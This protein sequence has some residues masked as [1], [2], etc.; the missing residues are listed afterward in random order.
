MQG[1]V[2]TTAT[3][4][5]EPTVKRPRDPR[6]QDAL[7]AV[8]RQR[9]LSKEQFAHEL[10][11]DALSRFVEEL[12]L[13]QASRLLVIGASSG[14][15]PSVLG[16]LVGRVWVLEPDRARVASLE[17]QI[18]AGSTECPNLAVVHGS[19]GSGVPGVGQVDAILQLAPPAHELA[20]TLLAHLAP[21]GRALVCADD[22]MPPRRAVRVAS[23]S[24][25][26]VTTEALEFPRFLLPLGDLLVAAGVV[27]YEQIDEAARV[28]RQN[29]RN[30]GAELLATGAIREEDLYRALAEQRGMDFAETRDVLASLDPE[31]VQQLPR[32]YLDHYRFIPVRRDKTRVYVVT[33]N[34]ELPLWELQGAFE[35]AEVVVQLTTPTDLQRMRT[36]IELGLVAPA[37]KVEEPPRAEAP[38]PALQ[39]EESSRATN[40]LDALLQDSAAERASDVHL[41][42]YE[43]GARVRFRI[44]GSLR[45][46]DRYHLSAAEFVALVN[47]LKIASG[48]DIAERRAPQSGRFHRRAGG[49][50]FDLRA[51]TQPALHGEHVILRM[52]PQNHKPPSIEG[53]GFPQAVAE[54]YRRLLQNPHG[55]VLVV[56]PTGSGKSTTLYAGLQTLATDPTRKVITVEDP[57]EYEIPRVQQTMINPAVGFHFADAV[58]AFVREDPDVILVGEIRDAE[59][60]L[61]AIRASQTGHLVLSTLHCN[62]TVDA[63]Q[64]LSDLGMHP[65]SIAS[66]LTAV[67]SQRLAR[68]ICATC[69]A[70]AK[71]DPALLAELFPHG[72]PADFACFAGRGCARCSGSGT[73]G[74]IAVVE[75]L[76]VGP[77]IRKA[78]S[79]RAVLDEVREIAGC[80]GLSSL[81]ESALQLVGQGLIPLAE[82]YDVLSAEQMAPAESRG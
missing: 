70:P 24:E 3:K 21:G 61:E 33:P 59:T 7:A 38:G 49:R 60:A 22:A 20:P 1:S 76:Q 58:R 67:M 77:T 47:V 65:N 51:Q 37:P 71:P 42:F 23:S 31:V 54:R 2:S 52:L 68:R 56:G 48:M 73:R 46:I 66:E 11:P 81:R 5:P 80:Q 55:L 15:V 44:D 43:S 12:G 6:L 82:L 62:D 69:K 53:L 45:D 64:R 25:G 17:R 30:L 74:R 27:L 16:K 40:T 29:R 10:P 32:K 34:L 26:V 79:R 36:A 18:G 41:E 19:V 35:G 72:A 4:P 14:Y 39:S 78:I 8:P 75:F 9:F 28:A 50:V 63:V 57:I 13:G